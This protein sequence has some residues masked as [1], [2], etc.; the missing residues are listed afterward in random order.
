MTLQ[1]IFENVSAG[2]IVSIIVIIL[3]L[4]EITP[5][6]LSPLQWIGNRINKPINDRL[7]KVEDKLELAN[8]KLD[9]H[10]A[11]SYR[12]SILNVQDRLIK[13]D[14]FTREEWKKAIKSCQAY[15]KYIEDNK[16]SNDLVEEAMAYIH[17]QYQ[18]ALDSS[19]FLDIPASMPGEKDKK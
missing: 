5:V 8:H 13:G 19:D 9:E 7:D 4:V 17:R 2:G 16:L 18:R 11:E 3:S 14:K 12:N 6:K 1:A 15:D 10:I